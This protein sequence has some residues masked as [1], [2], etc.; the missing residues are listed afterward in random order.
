MDPFESYAATL[1]RT[2]KLESVTVEFES[3]LEQNMETRN[4]QYS[5]K[6]TLSRTWK[7]ETVSTV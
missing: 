6:A 3:H 4:C 7:L 5:L 2:W 1:S